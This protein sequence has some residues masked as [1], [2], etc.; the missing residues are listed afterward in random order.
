MASTA[1]GY[2]FVKDPKALTI[3]LLVFLGMHFFMDLV[4]IGSAALEL[5]M[6]SRDF[7]DDEANLSVIRL[8]LIAMIYLATFLA[9]VVVF[10][11]W[12]YRANKNS[13]G[14]GARGMK[15]SPGWAVGWYF[16]P[17]LC[18]WKPFQSMR[19]MWQVSQPGP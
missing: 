9:T 13:H 5:E 14:F 10:C 11:M 1:N 2:S 8:A 7:T 19:E 6:L 15:F 12:V 4:V 3:V 18:L 16:I 17:F